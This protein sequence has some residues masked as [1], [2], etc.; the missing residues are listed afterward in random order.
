M[1]HAINAQK[2][3]LLHILRNN[4]VA[5]KYLI[6]PFT[7]VILLCGCKKSG[8]GSQNSGSTTPVVSITGPGLF[9]RFIVNTDVSFSVSLSVAATQ[10]VTVHYA[11]LDGS[12]KAGKDYVATSGDI[13]IKAGSS[14]PSQIKVQVK[15]DSTRSS[16]TE[17]FVALSNPKNCTISNDHIQGE[18]FID[19]TNGLYYP[20]DNSG[21][22]TPTHYPGYTLAWSDEFNGSAI[23]ESNWGFESGNNNGWGNHE[24]EYYTNS[25]NNAFVSAGNLIIEA[26][27]EP[28]GGFNY[29]SARMITKGKRSFKFGRI[30]IRAKLPKG[31]GIWPALWMLGNNIDAVSWPACGEMDIMEELGQQPNTI[32]GTLHWGTSP[33]GHSSKG[34]NYTLNGDFSQGFHLFSSV[35]QQDTIQLLVDNKPYLTVY[36]QNI[37]PANPF[38]DKFFFIFNVAVGGDWPGA[39]DGNALPA[40]MAVDYVRVYQ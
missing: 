34:T 21:D 38:N 15:G 23:D 3:H 10:D 16:T 22:T 4:I 32:Y 14:T 39:P 20:V 5:M 37:A 8:S 13:T 6:A 27:N 25:T 40:R 28:T 26:R 9:S 36:G 19:N 29:T 24:Q 11:T 7:C 17:F 30:D 31:Q 33:A 12:A 1:K 18:A 2:Q 35:W